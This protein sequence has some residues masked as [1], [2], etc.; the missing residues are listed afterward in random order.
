MAAPVN[1]GMGRQGKPR[2]ADGSGSD[3]DAGAVERQVY[4]LAAGQRGQHRASIRAGDECASR[5][6]DF[7]AGTGGR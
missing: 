4:R 1:P 5:L 6:A 2:V 3:D 7:G